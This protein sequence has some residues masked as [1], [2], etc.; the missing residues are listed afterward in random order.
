MESKVQSYGLTS[1]DL[2]LCTIIGIMQNVC[3]HSTWKYRIVIDL[4]YLFNFIDWN[5]VHW[6][7][8]MVAYRYLLRSYTL[9]KQSEL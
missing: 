1:G 9:E 3:A 7:L 2:N 5:D 8:V 4:M 6:K